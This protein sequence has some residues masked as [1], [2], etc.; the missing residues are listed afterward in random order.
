MRLPRLCGLQF[1]LLPGLL[2]LLSGCSAGTR[3]AYN[4]LDTIAA[5]QL[6]DFVELDP[7]QKAAHQTSFQSIWDWHRQTQLPAYARDLRE[8]AEAVEKS[9]PGPEAADA[10]LVKIERHGEVL[11]RRIVDG[12]APLLPTLSDAQAAGII[13][14]QR[15]DIEKQ[16]RVRAD[17]TPDQRHQRY[18]RGVAGS[19]DYW[20]GE[21]NAS[22]KNAADRVWAE[23]LA[24]RPTA[25]QRR[26]IR[27]DDLQR[28]AD[29]L[30]AR[31][32]PDFGKRLRKFFDDDDPQQQATERGRAEASAQARQRQLIV[33][34]LTTLDARQRRKLRARLLTLAEDCEA[35]AATRVASEAAAHP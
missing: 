3:F 26:Q 1:G 33:D 5:W 25:A 18:L 2:L 22:Q 32:A 17:E 16:E 31:H 14:Q 27:L 29:L 28:L 4:H 11:G 7:A 20:I 21:L 23:G 6:S 12:I 8:I 10:M 19:F 13:E 9:P 30:A 34:V 35:L 15:K 24:T